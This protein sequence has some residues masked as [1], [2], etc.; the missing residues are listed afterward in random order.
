MIEP[1]TATGVI[2][3][4][5]IIWAI[6][7]PI[8]GA[9]PKVREVIS[10]RYLVITVFLACMI[11]VIINFSELDTSV[12]VTVIVGASILSG[13]YIILR[14]WEKAAY[15]GW[16]SG[17]NIEASISKGDAKAELKLNQPKTERNDNASNE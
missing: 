1:Y 7:I 14:S 8:C 9:I 17:R 5:L 4:F 11:G 15:N 13:M 16:L 12:R 2:I 10:Y 3:A 6:I